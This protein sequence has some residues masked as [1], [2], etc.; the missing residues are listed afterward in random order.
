MSARKYYNYQET[1]DNVQ[2]KI[3]L[4]NFATEIGNNSRCCLTVATP[5]P[6]S[7]GY[8]H[9]ERIQ[10]RQTMVSV[11]RQYKLGN[12]GHI[13]THHCVPSIVIRYD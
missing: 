5:Q 1:I 11:V 2:K 13:F 12:L 8:R 9:T 6:T 10:K 7:L 4:W 3:K